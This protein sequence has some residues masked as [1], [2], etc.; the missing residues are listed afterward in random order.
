MWVD[1]LAVE[2]IKSRSARL[3]VMKS[4]SV[5]PIGESIRGRR[6]A[7]RSGRFGDLEWI[8]DPLTEPQSLRCVCVPIARASEFPLSA[9]AAR[10]QPSLKS[11]PRSESP[12]GRRGKHVALLL[13]APLRR[14]PSDRGATEERPRSDYRL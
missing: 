5:E 10:Y 4:P 9:V 7:P 12:S 8:A 1:A 11:R 6:C 14:R 13:I 2:Q 3:G